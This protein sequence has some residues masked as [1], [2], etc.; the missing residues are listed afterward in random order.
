VHRE[1]DVA[2]AADGAWQRNQG[3][4]CCLSNEQF[5][6]CSSPVH[7][8]SRTGGPK[9]GQAQGQAGGSA[10][11][12]L[13]QSIKI[14][15]AALDVIAGGHLSEAHLCEN[16]AELGAHLQGPQAACRNMCLMA[17]GGRM[18]LDSAAGTKS[19]K[20]R[21]HLQEGMQAACLHWQAQSIKVVG[22]EV[23]QRHVTGMWP[24]HAPT[25]HETH[26]MR[27]NIALQACCATCWNG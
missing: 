22:F 3:L 17:A 9:P 18:H 23:L 26:K 25:Q 14:P 5:V 11:A 27:R 13:K 8:C 24:S 1:R 19:A 16:L 4:S 10:S 6:G 12:H 21:T 20:Q 2:G 15:E 7:A